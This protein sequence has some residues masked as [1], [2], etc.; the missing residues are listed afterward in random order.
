MENGPLVEVD[1]LLDSAYCAVVQNLNGNLAPKD[2]T[3]GSGVG[4]GP[5]LGLSGVSLEDDGNMGPLITLADE[6]DSVPSNNGFLFSKVGCSG[7]INVPDKLRS[8]L[9]SQILP[10]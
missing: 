10:C 9:W 4:M 8:Y 5:S 3:P 2:D 6:K 7:K 1:S